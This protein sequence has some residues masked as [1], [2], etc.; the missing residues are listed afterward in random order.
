MTVADALLLIP[1]GSIILLSLPLGYINDKYLKSASVKLRVL[2]VSILLIPISYIIMMQYASNKMNESLFVSYESTSSIAVIFAMVLLG[3]GYGI[4]NCMFWT[5]LIE[6]VPG[7]LIGPASGLLASGL[8]V[9]PSLVPFIVMTFFTH[10]SD[11]WTMILLSLVGFTSS[12][13]ALYDSHVTTLDSSS[14]ADS[15]VHFSPF[16]PRLRANSGSFGP[17]AI[18]TDG[19]IEIF[20][21]PLTKQVSFGYRI[22]S[23]EEDYLMQKQRNNKYATYD[24]VSISSVDDHRL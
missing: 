16:S 7:E 20:S 14:H 15:D 5:I 23:D 10:R 21:T 11:H 9:L 19:D 22:A 17:L 13:L 1:E 12:M 6:V 3:F 18:L 8:N 4:S 2:S 24:A